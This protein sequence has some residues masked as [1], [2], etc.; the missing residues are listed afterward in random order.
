MHAKDGSQQVTCLCHRR[1]LRRQ[2]ARAD[3]R[4]RQR[5]GHAL[6]V[7]THRQVRGFRSFGGGVDNK[8]RGGAGQRQGAVAPRFEGSFHQKGQ[9]SHAAAR[10]AEQQK[11]TEALCSAH[12]L[13]VH[14]LGQGSNSTQTHSAMCNLCP[15]TAAEVYLSTAPAVPRSLRSLNHSREEAGRACSGGAEREL[16]C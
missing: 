7:R 16:P 4:Q 6:L 5:A 12:A 11:H 15:P 14:Q 10:G 1:K 2:Q 3:L 9:T 8:G 13:C